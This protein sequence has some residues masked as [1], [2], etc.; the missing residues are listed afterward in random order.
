M[1][2]YVLIQIGGDKAGDE[3][4]PETQGAYKDVLVIDVTP[5]DNCFIKKGG[6]EVAFNPGSLDW[7]EICIEFKD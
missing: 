5:G 1:D 3:P 7:R 2:D 6:S 4:H